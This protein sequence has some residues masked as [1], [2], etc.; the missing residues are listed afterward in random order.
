[1]SVGEEDVLRL[2][3]AVDHAVRVRR[4]ERVG[5][6]AR[7]LH[8]FVHRK[9]PRALESVAERFAGHEGSHVIEEP[10]ARAESE[11]G[12][13]VRM[14]DLRR[15]RCLAL[16][17]RDARLARELRRKDLHHHLPPQAR[18][19]GEEDVAHPPATQLTDEAVLVSE[20]L[21]ERCGDVFHCDLLRGGAR[22]ARR[23][24]RVW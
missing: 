8:G 11:H 20:R 1:V 16:E 17:A 7:E 12:E 6:L 15:E 9:R 22:E 21:L 5:H 14:L 23:R 2:D 13:D 3:V 18:L 19:L 10:V 24:H 4:R